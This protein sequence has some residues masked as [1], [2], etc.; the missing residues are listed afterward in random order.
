MIDVV[1]QVREK[2]PTPLGERH[3]EFLVEVAR[4]TSKGLLRKTSGTRVQTEFGEVAQDILVD[5]GGTMHYDILED[6]EGIAKPIW[7]QVGP[8]EAGR[9][10]SVSEEPKPEPKPAPD[11]TPKSGLEDLI[12][13]KFVLLHITLGQEI[14]RLRDEIARIKSQTYEGTAS[15]R[16]LGSIK[17]TLTPKE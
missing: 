4:A 2:Y 12:E 9:Y 17:F 16:L 6:G 13:E 3:G 14:G 11:P 8:Y 5:F 15:N 1:R 10:V 7:N